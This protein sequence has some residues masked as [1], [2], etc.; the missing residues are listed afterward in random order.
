MNKLLTTY[1]FEFGNRSLS[2]CYGVTAYSFEDAIHILKQKIFIK[3][4][5][6]EIKNCKE[7]IRFADLDPDHI[8]PNMGIIIN[9]GI[10]YPIGFSH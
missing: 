1:W 6:P 5:M 10:W 2:N 4:E 9:R 8:A 7:N 3:E